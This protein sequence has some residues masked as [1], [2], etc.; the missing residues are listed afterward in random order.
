MFSNTRRRVVEFVCFRLSFFFAEHWR[1]APPIT[2]HKQENQ[3]QQTNSLRT[4][5]QTLTFLWLLQLQP[6]KKELLSWLREK[7]E[8][9]QPA[10][11][12]FAEHYGG[13]PPITHHKVNSIGLP[14]LPR[15]G[16]S[17]WNQ[18]NL[19]IRKRRLMEE[20]EKSGPGCR[21]HSRCI[22]IPFKI[23][24]IKFTNLFIP[25]TCNSYTDVKLLL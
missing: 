16:R 24:F 23:C 12:P 1:V 2:L 25:W 10:C 14:V 3:T 15:Q 4:N 13:E 19:P 18:F 21:Q 20:R 8:L 5:S 17:K 7:R 6:R 9:V 11:L 22:S